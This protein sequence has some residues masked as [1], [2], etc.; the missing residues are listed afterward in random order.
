VNEIQPN[1][2]T[3]TGQCKIKHIFK[4]KKAEIVWLLYRYGVSLQMKRAKAL[5]VSQALYQSLSNY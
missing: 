1:G 5:I 2:R 4:K 3:K